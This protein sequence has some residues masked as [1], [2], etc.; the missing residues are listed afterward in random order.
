MIPKLLRI[1]PLVGLLAACGEEPAKPRNALLAFVPA[2]TSYAFVISRPL[3]DG[4]R[5]RL[6]EYYAL[7]LSRPRQSH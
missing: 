1:L 5:D 2:D 7:Q 6:A 3:P 4:L